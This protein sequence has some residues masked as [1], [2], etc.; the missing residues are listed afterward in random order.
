MQAG[1]HSMH[2]ALAR[3]ASNPDPKPGPASKP[4]TVLWQEAAVAYE[5]RCLVPHRRSFPQ[6]MVNLLATP[7][8]LCKGWQSRSKL[9]PA[10]YE[11]AQTS[12]EKR[13]SDSNTQFADKWHKV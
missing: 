13:Q 9:T 7:V 1:M 4:N 8:T 6:N 12:E 3:A 10:P 5:A 11:K 2:A